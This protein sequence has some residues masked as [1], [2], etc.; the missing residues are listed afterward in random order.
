MKLSL[1]LL[2]LISIYQANSKLCLISLSLYMHWIER[3]KILD[4]L[5]TDI[6][7]W[8]ADTNMSILALA[9]FYDNYW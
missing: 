7:T 2:S 1:L 6:A 5:D 8:F 4:R 9:M 3:V